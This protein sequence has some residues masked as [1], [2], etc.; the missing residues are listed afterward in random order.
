MIAAVQIGQPRAIPLATAATALRS[1][2]KREPG[3]KCRARRQ[4][5][6]VIT[7]RRS[8]SSTKRPVVASHILHKKLFGQGG[9][10]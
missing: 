8:T 4:H 6:G 10:W 7:L 3:T 1:R 9:V 5:A 2:G